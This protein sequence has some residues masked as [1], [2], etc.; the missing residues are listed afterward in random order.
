M[1]HATATARRLVRRRRWDRV[2]T[3]LS[4]R[5]GV[6]TAS[7]PERPR[8]TRDVAVAGGVARAWARRLR[9]VAGGTVG[10]QPHPRRSRR[11]CSPAG[12]WGPAPR[13]GEDDD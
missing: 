3:R 4:P 5:P 9:L 12:R 6:T 10:P 13:R 1:A 8:L 2:G 11:R 7:S